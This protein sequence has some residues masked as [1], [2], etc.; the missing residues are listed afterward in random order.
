[1]LMTASLAARALPLWIGAALLLTGCTSPSSESAPDA[2]EPPSFEAQT[3]ADFLTGGVWNDGQAEVAFYRVQRSHDQ[4]DRPNVQT[5]MVGTYLVKH[6]FSPEAMSKVTD[7]SGVSAFKS[8]LFYELESGSYQYKRNWVVNA[9][10]SDL[11]P[12]KHSFTSFDWCSNQYRE[13]AFHPDGTVERRMRSDDYGNTHRTFEGTKAAVP[14]A[15]LP[16]LVRS[17]L[18]DG[19]DMQSVDVL[20]RDGSTVPAAA[21]IEGTETVDTPAGEI[22]AERIRVTYEG[23]VP[24][25]IAEETPGPETYWRG[26]GEERRLVKVAGEGYTMT[27]VEHLRTPYWQENL[28]PRLERVSERP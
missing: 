23:T 26:M 25:M 5:F 18:F 14:P 27:L 2:G 1:M 28:W 20:K 17:L 3:D 21:R 10:Q 16:L 19:Q 24:S 12:I 9:R 7:G 4:Y 13:W 11:R 22:E 15:L 8:A 6:R